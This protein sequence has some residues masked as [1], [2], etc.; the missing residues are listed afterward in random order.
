MKNR[1]LHSNRLSSDKNKLEVIFA[2]EWEKAN[3]SF[4]SSSILLDYMLS[5]SSDYPHRVSSREQE[6]AATLIQWMGTEIGQG[7]LKDVYERGLKE[8]V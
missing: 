3:E 4:S 7:F 6:V 5:Q 8:L 1:G 2:E